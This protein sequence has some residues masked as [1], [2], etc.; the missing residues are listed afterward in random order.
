MTYDPKTGRDSDFNFN[1]ANPP[2]QQYTPDIGPRPPQPDPDPAVGPSLDPYTESTLRAAGQL[3]EDN[4]G[5]PSPRPVS[6]REALERN[7]DYIRSKTDPMEGLPAEIPAWMM[8]TPAAQL[9]QA[10][11]QLQSAVTRLNSAHK[12]MRVLIVILVVYLIVQTIG[13]VLRFT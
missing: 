5:L 4:D 8:Q 3:P 6:F 10:R 1:P 7:P 11:D 2:G 12:A 13:L 9:E